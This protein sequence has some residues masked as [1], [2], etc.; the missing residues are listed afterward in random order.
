MNKI[1][2][3]ILL[4]FI[5]SFLG[6]LIEVIMIS[7]QK[8]RIVNRG[9]LLGPIC[10]IY[11][12]G[13]LF[14]IL[15]LKKYYYDPIAFFVM[16][17]TI[18]SILEYFTSYIMEKLFKARWW[19]YSQRKFNI[20]GRICLLNLVWFGFLGIIVIY[21][22]DKPITNMLNNLS[23]ITMQ[24]LSI[25]FMILFIID[26]IVTFNVITKFKQTALTIR[27]DSTE[28]ITRLIRQKLSENFLSR[29]L[30]TAFNFKPSESLIK[31]IKER[32]KEAQI[33]AQTKIKDQKELLQNKAK[34]N[35]NKL[36]A[37]KEEIHTIIKNRKS[38][39]NVQKEK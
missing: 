10:P 22:L 35:I 38:D 36:K 6:W 24:I 1:Y 7:I 17:I 3:Y 13:C 16:T 23:L 26:T 5:Y 11:G 19:D 9:F 14:I 12:F 4:F 20:A 34:N 33:K 31:E 32:I 2:F 39:K 28:E 15:F 18:C 25:S 8:H 30:I 27:K 21:V 29:R 37:K